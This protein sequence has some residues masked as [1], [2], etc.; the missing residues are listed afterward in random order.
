MSTCWHHIKAG[1]T[2]QQPDV[3][4]YLVV[5]VFVQLHLALMASSISS[6][7][8]NLGNDSLQNS[9]NRSC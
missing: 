7:P 4:P 9:N 3:A 8:L 5:H 1:T 6:S 2:G